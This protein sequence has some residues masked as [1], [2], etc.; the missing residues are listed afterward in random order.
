M[1]G[2]TFVAEMIKALAWP[3]A[4]S[5]A[6]LVLRREIKGLLPLI[7]KLK[8][9]PIEAEFDREVRELKEQ[10]ERQPHRTE[11]RPSLDFRAS[12]IASAG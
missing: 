12:D 8:A 9:G 11:L 3:M 5:I 1:D 7:K 6:V 2:L 10:A 4:A